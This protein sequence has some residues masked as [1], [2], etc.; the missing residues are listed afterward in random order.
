MEKEQLENELKEYLKENLD[1]FITNQ[2]WVVIKQL[3]DFNK[4]KFKDFL[5]KE[6]K[7]V[8]GELLFKFVVF[9]GKED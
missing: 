8:G 7:N 4:E 2:A 5:I 1:L 6:K 3:K 9:Q